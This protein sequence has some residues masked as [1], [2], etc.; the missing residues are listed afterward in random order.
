MPRS[1]R[2][3]CA[4]CQRVRCEKGRKFCSDECRQLAR[5]GQEV[6]P[7]PEEIARMCR[8]IREEGGEEWERNRTCYPPRSV[9]IPHWSIS[10][11]DTLLR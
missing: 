8:Q 9:E 7:S 6:S 4:W 5:Q 3:L 11:G 10:S 1:E 2:P